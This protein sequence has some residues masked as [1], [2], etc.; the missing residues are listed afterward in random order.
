MMAGYVVKTSMHLALG[1]YMLFWNRKWDRMAIE[2]GEDL[3]VEERKK[4]A[5]EIGMVSLG[6]SL[7]GM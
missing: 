6:F 3:S 4:K 5:E 2:R 7:L 1:L